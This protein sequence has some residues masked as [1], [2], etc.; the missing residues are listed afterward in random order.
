M[1]AVTVTTNLCHLR[2]LQQII[3]ATWQY[4][5]MTT[6]NQNYMHHL[7]PA[8]MDAAFLHKTSPGNP[9]LSTTMHLP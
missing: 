1:D 9:I 3:L 8:K 7:G 4:F 5:L 2:F 6:M